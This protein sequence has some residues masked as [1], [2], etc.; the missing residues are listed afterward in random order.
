M[1]TS[2]TSLAHIFRTR[3]WFENNETFIFLL[4]PFQTFKFRFADLSQV[5]Y[6]TKANDIQLSFIGTNSSSKQCTG[7]YPAQLVGGRWPPSPQCIGA[8]PPDAQAAVGVCWYIP[9]GEDTP[10]EPPP[11][12]ARLPSGSTT[13]GPWPVV[14]KC[15]LRRGPTKRTERPGHPQTLPLRFPPAGRSPPFQPVSFCHK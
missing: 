2:A 9:A 11:E 6:T 10:A 3:Y 5:Q 15:A 13:I 7:I 12:G 14:S 1:Y 8:A 4:F